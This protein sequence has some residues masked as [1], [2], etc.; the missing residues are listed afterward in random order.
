MNYQPANA[1][2]GRI[3]SDQNYYRMIRDLIQHPKVI[4]MENYIQHGTTT[5]LTHC[6]QVS[7]AGYTMAK[8]LGWSES[9]IRQTARGGLLHDFFLYDWHDYHTPKGV[10]LP[11]GF[12]HPYVALKN[13]KR[14]FSLTR[15]EKDII[16]KHMW[17]LT[18]FLP[19]YK[20]SYLIMAAD[21][22]CALRETVSR[23]SVRLLSA[24]PALAR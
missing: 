22:Y 10:L 20:E 13:A 1:E 3:L 7:Y 15:R 14:Y 11:H 21:K 24:V 12:T 2:E 19:R 5:C 8:S 18:V 9:S 6:L 23:M 16:V 4:S 17:P